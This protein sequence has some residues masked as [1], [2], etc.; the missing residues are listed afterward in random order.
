MIEDETK[1]II[2]EA[3]DAFGINAKHEKRLVVSLNVLAWISRL[4][5]LFKNKSKKTERND[6]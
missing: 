6:D 1:K 3:A 2:H 5:Y 4:W